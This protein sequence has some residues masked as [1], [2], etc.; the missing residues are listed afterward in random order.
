MS[1][2]A[3]RIPGVADRLR[4][5]QASIKNLEALDRF[6]NLIIKVVISSL[7]ASLIFRIPLIRELYHEDPLEDLILLIIVILGYF[8]I[9]GVLSW[10]FQIATARDAIRLAKLLVAKRSRD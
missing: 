1:G 8:F 6:G 10:L 7:I 4:K 5:N 2:K 3:S 9:F